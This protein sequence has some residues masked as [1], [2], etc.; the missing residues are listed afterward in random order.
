MDEGRREGRG[1]RLD[2]DSD[3]TTAR[4]EGERTLQRP[5][6]Q[7]RSIQTHRASPHTYHRKIVLDSSCQSYRRSKAGRFAPRAEGKG[8]LDQSWI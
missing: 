4:E 5:L 7:R 1:Q 2:L 3:A 8:S 6:L